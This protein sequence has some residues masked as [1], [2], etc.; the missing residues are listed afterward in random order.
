MSE[1]VGE[2]VLCPGTYSCLI[3]IKSLRCKI[4]S[5]RPMQRWHRRW[6][7]S[8]LQETHLERDGVRQGDEHR[9]LCE[10]D[11]QAA[12]QRAHDEGGLGVFGSREELVDH[13]DLGVLALVAFHLGDG[14]Q[15]AKDALHG[16]NRLVCAYECRRSSVV[17]DGQQLA[18]D[19]LHRKHPHW[20]SCHQ[21]L[22]T[23]T[24]CHQPTVTSSCPGAGRKSFSATAGTRTHLDGQLAS[25]NK[26]IGSLNTSTH[27]I[28]G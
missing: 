13:L 12:L 21:Q 15:L 4:S 6:Q 10:A 14:Q 26:R 24:H 7:T 17:V 19:A 9:L 27:L 11:A 28:R 25:Y 1:R 16:N 23:V 20:T 18:K 5:A 2:C 3:L 8:R 22:P